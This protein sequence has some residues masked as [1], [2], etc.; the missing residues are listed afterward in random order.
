MAETDLHRVAASL[1][2]PEERAASPHVDS[3]VREAAEVWGSLAARDEVIRLLA[4]HHVLAEVPFSLRIDDE[5]RP[6][7]LRGTID[8]LAI[9]ADGSVTVVELKTGQ[10]R[11]FHQAQL[12]VYM[13]A[14]RSL[15][16]GRT[17]EGRLLYHAGSR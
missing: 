5:E 2:R 8:G 4:S 10:A 1:L 17:V 7:I 16:P 13:R 11:A 12:D 15:F 14:A 3:I 9:A 6:V